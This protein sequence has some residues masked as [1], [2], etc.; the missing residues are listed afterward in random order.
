M[1]NEVSVSGNADIIASELIAAEL[2]MLL[3]RQ[4]WMKEVCVLKGDIKDAKSGT[5]KIG[6]IKLD[7]VAESV[8]EGNAVSATTAL[9][10]GSYSLSPGRLT[11]KRE[12]SDLMDIITPEGY[13]SP[14]V[15]AEFNHRAIML[16]FDA[17]VC[18]A[19]TNFTGS[20]GTSGS[21]LTLLDFRA[22]FQTLMERNAAG[23]VPR[24]V[25]VLHEGQFAD[26]QNDLLQ[27]NAVALDRPDVKDIVQMRPTNFK[28]L[29]DGVE[30]WTSNQ[31]NSAN[32]GADYNG[33]MFIMGGLGYAQGG[34][35]PGMFGR[36]V[37][38]DTV[39]YTQFDVDIDRAEQLMTTNGFYAVSVS[40][41]A[42]GIGVITQQ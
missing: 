15:L 37:H 30:I 21:A 17:L 16:G 13:I 40:E 3:A 19:G 42:K 7:D 22:G 24:M 18:T 11:I 6:Q 26:L 41:A 9:T 31:V 20:V 5:I 25:C 14:S 1:A 35:K 2:E 8:A 28:G 32:S 10:D 33:F 36:Q 23:Q 39:V 27:Y 12:I 34:A 38:Q 4:P 29:L